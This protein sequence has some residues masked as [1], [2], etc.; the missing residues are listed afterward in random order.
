MERIGIEPMTSSLQSHSGG[1]DS[2]RPAA[3]IG[4]IHAG[5]RATQGSR[6]AWF[7]RLV[8]GRLG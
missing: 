3:T 5:L 8:F 7:R 4:S 6:P 1:R 2:R